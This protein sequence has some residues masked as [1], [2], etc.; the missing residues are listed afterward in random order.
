M[1]KEL[2]ILGVVA[3][4]TLLLYWGVEPFAHSQ[5]HKHVEGHGLVY[6]G[7]AE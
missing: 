2:K 1:N 6:D 3:A 4:F 7:K 5:M